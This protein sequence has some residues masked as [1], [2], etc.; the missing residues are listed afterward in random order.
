MSYVVRPG[1]GA[2]R[3][4]EYLQRGGSASPSELAEGAQIGA[5]SLATLI[6]GAI[7]AGL[8]ERTGKSNAIVY[9]LPGPSVED[10]PPVF[11]LALWLDGELTIC[12]AEQHDNGSVVLKRD[13]VA[14]LRV[15][16]AP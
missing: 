12:G 13:Q 16:L 3:A 8:I 5:G 7:R 11:N 6:R 10:P 15:F 1:S 14:Q 9:S 2:A 4:I